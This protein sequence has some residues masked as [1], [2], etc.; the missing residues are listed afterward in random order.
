MAIRGEN[1]PEL[2]REHDVLASVTHEDL[3]HA[4]GRR[5]AQR[6]HTRRGARRLDRRENPGTVECR[7]LA[8]PRRA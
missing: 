7:P 3:R 5:G 6:Q 1:K 2:G 4:A 8:G